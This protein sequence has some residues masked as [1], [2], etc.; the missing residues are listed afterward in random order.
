MPRAVN[1]TQVL[2]EVAKCGCGVGSDMDDCTVLVGGGNHDGY[3]DCKC[4]CCILDDAGSVKHGRA[5]M[6]AGFTM[7]ESYRPRRRSYRRR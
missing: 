2:N 6:D 3:W 4:C 5:E 7:G 1:E